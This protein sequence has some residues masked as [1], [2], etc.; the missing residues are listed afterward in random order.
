MSWRPSPEL[1]G[2]SQSAGEAYAVRTDPSVGAL[3]RSADCRLRSP[4]CLLRRTPPPPGTSSSC[5]SCSPSVSVSYVEVAVAEVRSAAGVAVAEVRTDQGASSGRT[6][7]QARALVTA[8][9]SRG[10]SCRSGFTVLLV[11]TAGKRSMRSPVQR[12]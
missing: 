7:Q 6:E 4:R 12:P 1:S 8:L 5:R 9:V 2:N 11:L 10:S 3:L